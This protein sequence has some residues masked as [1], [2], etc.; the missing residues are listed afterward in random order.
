M[1]VTL[2]LLCGSLRAGS[3]NEA[4]LRTV[5]AVAPEGVQTPLYDGMARL[6]HFNPDDDG[7]DLDAEVVALRA[8]VGASDA[9]LIC[10]PE[11]AGALPGSFKN[12][13]DWTVGGA[14]MD[15]RPV[16]WINASGIAAPSGGKDAHDSLRK[17]LGF[18]NAAVVEDAVARVP[19]ARDA[20][21]TD[22]TVADPEARAAIADAVSALAQHVS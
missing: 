7:E 10:T 9:V 17:V 16:A 8:A 20:I 11:Y 3:V 14:E 22:G 5:Q 15:R 1:S 6:A 13:L 2:L 21:G 12:L 19:V 18:V 4:V